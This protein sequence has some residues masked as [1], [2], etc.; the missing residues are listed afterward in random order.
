MLLGHLHRQQQRLHSAAR[1]QHVGIVAVSGR[2]VTAELVW[3][4]PIADQAEGVDLLVH[5]ARLASPELFGVRPELDGVPPIEGAEQDG[6]SDV[7]V[8][9]VDTMHLAP[10]GFD[11]PLL[12]DCEATGMLLHLNVNV[13]GERVRP[14]RI[15]QSF[16]IDGSVL[17]LASSARAVRCGGLVGDPTFVVGASRGWRVRHVVVER[18]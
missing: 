7:V 2:G 16:S 17:M 11:P 8:R 5:G 12:Q 1:R 6:E 4:Q 9:D 10:L 15:G 13:D 18:G 14:F 3:R